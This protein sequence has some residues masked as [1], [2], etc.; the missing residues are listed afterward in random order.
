MS[1]TPPLDW[2]AFRQRR[3]ASMEKNSS[4][5]GPEV[6]KIEQCRF[7]TEGVNCVATTTNKIV[8]EQLEREHGTTLVHVCCNA[9]TTAL[10][11]PT[12]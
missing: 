4:A 10:S 1:V 7:S 5:V 3:F 8:L 6:Y 12:R 9:T 2:I 11:I